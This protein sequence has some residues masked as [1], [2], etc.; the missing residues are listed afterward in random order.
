VKIWM[1]WQGGANYTVGTVE[2]DI[3]EFDTVAAARE[4]FEARENGDRH[5]FPMVEGSTA[6]VFL[7]DPRGEMDPYPDR[8]W[9]FGPR[10]GFTSTPA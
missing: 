1:L 3:E 4:E 7:R 2:D 10:G 9:E 8:V 5:W 6:H